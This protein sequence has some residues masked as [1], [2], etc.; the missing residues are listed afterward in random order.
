MEPLKAGCL[1]K[2]PFSTSLGVSG[3]GLAE[4]PSVSPVVL[5][6]LEACA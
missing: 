4:S 2:N 6:C 5:F 1:R 3:I